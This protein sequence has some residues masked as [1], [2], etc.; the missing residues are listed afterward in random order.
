MS[1]IR[2][3]DSIMEWMSTEIEEKRIINPHLF[4]EAAKCM[5]ALIGGEHEKLWNYKQQVA[6]AR[7]DARK[8]VKTMAEANAIVESTDVYRMTKLQE[9]KIDQINEMIRLAKLQARLS[10]EEQK[11]Y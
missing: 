7:V 9:A 5:N 6:Q 3:V 1:E 10:S 11:N 8:I 4:V 2:T